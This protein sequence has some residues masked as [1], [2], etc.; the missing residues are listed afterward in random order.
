MLQGYVASQASEP[1]P[2]GRLTDTV[3]KETR[4]RSVGEE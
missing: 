1:I 3:F 2:N 4:S